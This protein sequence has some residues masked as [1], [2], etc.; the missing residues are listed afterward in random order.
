LLGT[1]APGTGSIFDK[2]APFVPGTTTSTLPIGCGDAMPNFNTTGIEYYT[3]AHKDC[4]IAFFT[5]LAKTP[6]SWPCQTR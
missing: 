4:L 3:Q 5:L 1:A 2:M 6:G